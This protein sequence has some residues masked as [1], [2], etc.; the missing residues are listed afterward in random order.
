MTDYRETENKETNNK[1]LITRFD[2]NLDYTFEDLD[3]SWLS[4][5]EKMNKE[6]QIC[7]NENLLFVKVNY[8]Y[9][10]CNQEITNV[11]EEKYF[12]K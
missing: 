10:N 6:N 11:G 5:F 4:E 12:F 1:E 7:Y 8:I 3:T 2:D 9:V